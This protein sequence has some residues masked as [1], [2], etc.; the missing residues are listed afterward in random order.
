L[1]TSA[2]TGQNDANGNP[3][4]APVT[5]GVIA[6]P[7]FVMGDPGQFN[8]ARLIASSIRISYTGKAFEKTGTITSGVGIGAN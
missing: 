6:G 4:S 7:P 3:L 2:L 8:H 5:P 1:A